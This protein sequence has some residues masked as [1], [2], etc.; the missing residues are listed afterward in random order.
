[1]VVGKPQSSHAFTKPHRTVYETSRAIQNK[2]PT[3]EILADENQCLQDEGIDYSSHCMRAFVWDFED[4][5]KVPYVLNGVPMRGTLWE[6]SNSHTKALI[7]LVKL[8]FT[9]KINH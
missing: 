7:Q 8:N 1:M 4:F 2:L 3:N 5:Q 6:P 9:S